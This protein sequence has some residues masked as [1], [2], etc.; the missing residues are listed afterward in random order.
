MLFYIIGSV[1]VI[2]SV[3]NDKVNEV[4]LEA[5]N[6]ARF[7]K[8]SF[9]RYID[10]VALAVV[11]AAGDLE[12]IDFTRPDARAMGEQ[13]LLSGIK[14]NMVINSWMIFEPNAFDGKDAEHKGK[15]PGET[16]GRYMRSYV[17]QGASYL[18]APDMDETLLD[19]MNAAYWYL[20]PKQRQAPFLDIAGEYGFAWDYG[21]GEGPVN[22]ISLVV[23]MF[24]N[25]AFIG[26]V[27]QDIQLTGEML[28]LE[29]IPGAVSALFTPAG[30]LRYCEKI[31]AVGK[32]LGELGFANAGRI[33][34]AMDREEMVI[35][36]GEY[37]PLLQATAFACFL[38]VKLVDFDELV[39]VYAAIPE[40][41]VQKAMAPII[42]S[43]LL[44]FV[45]LLIIFVL[46]LSYF[47]RRVS[48]PVHNL[49]L[50]CDAIS[51]GKFDTEIVRFNTKDEIGFMTQSLYRMVEQFRLHIAMRDRYQKLLDIYTRLY[52]ALYRYGRMEEVFDEIIPVVSDFFKVRRVFLVLVSGETARIRASYEPGTGPQRVEG[53]EFAHHRQVKS[54]LPGKK[55]I[56]WNA[57]ALREQKIG[58]VDDWVL[59]LCILP[60]FVVNELRGYIVMEGDSETGPLVHNDAVLLFLSETISYL[61]AQQ[62]GAGSL[63]GESSIPSPVP[64]P[65]IPDPQA[66]APAAAPDPSSAA[67][68]EGE[69]GAPADREELPVIKAARAIEGLDVDKGLFHSGGDAEQYGDL[70]RISARSFAGKTQKMRSLY[71]ADIPAFAIEVH[72]IK[73]ALYAIGA[74]ALGDEAKEL[75]F[76]AKAGDAGR[77]AQGYPAFEEKISAFTGQ[78]EAITKK[79][80]IPSKGPGGLPVL[81]AALEEA[82]EASRMF[83]STKAG[84][85]I[86]SL[87]GY[88][89]D[90]CA[91]TEGPAESPPRI[92][93]ILESIAD[94]LECME[95]DGAERD[96]VLLLE[97]FRPKGAPHTGNENT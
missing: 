45:V 93:E 24:R 50:V 96:M 44:F 29:M 78:L 36:S 20:V 5:K 7:N 65:Q 2:H 67:L 79:R 94:A 8:V 68:P 42:N 23:P 81:I 70:L 85:L 89:W 97:Y 90:D 63:K 62:E 87:L 53:Q 18:E 21:V 43:V 39:Y 66:E 95:Y 33:E 64:T 38:P 58:F 37:S 83:D 6:L 74:S 25:G 32:S 72:G 77:C 54:F 46:F 60:F 59:S 47:F 86:T 75:E 76:A 14:N 56:S 9:Q 3:F 26:C 57:S 92:A 11:S 52:K 27:G 30:L 13:V 17:R 41:K 28:G 91:G 10:T 40:S 49:I 31:D 55:Y 34:E 84:E 61:L 22:S 4:E 73:G 12:G 48:K 35:L 88:S 15:Y 82:L 69:P 71:Q 19:D 16:S 51:R 1:F 80:E